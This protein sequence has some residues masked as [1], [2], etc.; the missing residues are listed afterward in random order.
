MICPTKFFC[1]NESTFYLLTAIVLIVSVYTY[2]KYRMDDIQEDGRTV[3]IN[4]QS[5]KNI[6]LGLGAGL[7][8]GLGL[9]LDDI[10]I[11]RAL[12]SKEHD[13]YVQ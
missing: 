7:G 8:L 11:Q 4:Q 1:M 10:Q 12:I 13:S 5:T 6:H 2:N 3:K 9:G